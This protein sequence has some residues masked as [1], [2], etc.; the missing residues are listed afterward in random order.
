MPGL[1]LPAQRPSGAEMGRVVGII[2]TPPDFLRARGCSHEIRK[3]VD[4]TNDSGLNDS[5]RHV[6]LADLAFPRLHH[7]VIEHFV[8]YV[9]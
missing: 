2:G 7:C 8:R 9:A 4:E 5:V 3:S 1:R 6:V